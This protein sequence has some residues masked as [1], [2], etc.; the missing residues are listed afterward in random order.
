M[1]ICII[2]NIFR[3]MRSSLGTDV[4]TEC[5]QQMFSSDEVFIQTDLDYTRLRNIIFPKSGFSFEKWYMYQDENYKVPDRLLEFKYFDC[6][7]IVGYEIPPSLCKFFTKNN[8]IY[9]NFFTH[10]VRF[11]PDLLWAVTTN[12]QEIFYIL[13]KYSFKIEP[14]DSINRIKFQTLKDRNR[15]E[16]ELTKNTAIIFGQTPYDASVLVDGEFKTLYDFRHEIKQLVSNSD[17]ILIVPHPLLSDYAPIFALIEYLGKGKICNFNSYSL[18]S[19]S[20]VSKVITL[21]SSLGVEAKYFGKESHMLLGEALREGGGLRESGSYMTSISASILSREMWQDIASV[22]CHK[23]YGVHHRN[24][25]D[26]DCTGQEFVETNFFRGIFGG[27][28]M[29]NFDKPLEIIGTISELTGYISNGIRGIDILEFRKIVFS[30]RYMGKYYYSEGLSDFE[31]DGRW[32]DGETISLKFYKIPSAKSLKITVKPYISDSCPEQ[33]VNIKINGFKYKIFSLSSSTECNIYLNLPKC[34]Y[35]ISL[36]I[37]LPMLSGVKH[38]TEN[39]NRILGI[40]FVELLQMD[41]KYAICDETVLLEMQE[42]IVNN[43]D[44]QLNEKTDESSSFISKIRN[45]NLF[46]RN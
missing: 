33:I 46:Q 17:D 14:Q 39:D 23:F 40:K 19:S 45:L 3:W 31:A 35:E 15:F 9:I 36:T 13:G 43:I 34:S 26:Y 11:L 38:V 2:G 10:P 22:V 30:D 4:I 12:S 44:N 25:L 5:I 21:S 18:L 1:K 32:T 28:G 16:C 24:S 7:L 41:T 8:L 20:K 37:S 6:D 29:D 27:W 42:P